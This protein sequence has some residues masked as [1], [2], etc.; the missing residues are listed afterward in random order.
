MCQR[1]GAADAA[2]GVAAVFFSVLLKP[3]GAPLPAVLPAADAN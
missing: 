2:H 1:K 3:V